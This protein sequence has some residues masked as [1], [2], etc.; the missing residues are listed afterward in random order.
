[1]PLD[2]IPS[3]IHVIIAYESYMSL[4]MRSSKSYWC[5]TNLRY[6]GQDCIK[7]YINLKR[8]KIIVRGVPIANRTI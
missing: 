3:D 8:K 4:L 6:D 1:M 2:S 7:S 5:F